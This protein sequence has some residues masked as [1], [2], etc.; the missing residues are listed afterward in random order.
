MAVA[1]QQ[2]S[3]HQLGIDRRSTSMAVKWRE[4]PMQTAQVQPTPWSLFG[5]IQRGQG[6]VYLQR[7]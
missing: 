4:L 7:R 6:D 1:G 3:D 5:A 2:H